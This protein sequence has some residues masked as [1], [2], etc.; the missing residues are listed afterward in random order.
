[1][2]IGPIAVAPHR[3]INGIASTRAKAA[4]A[5]VGCE[6]TALTVRALPVFSTAT[7]ALAAAEV[8]EL[9][10]GAEPIAV[11]TRRARARRFRI[12]WVGQAKLA[13]VDLLIKGFKT[14]KKNVNKKNKKTVD[15]TKHIDT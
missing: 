5:V 13:A 3:Q 15:M 2:K 8:A 10:F 1:L 7:A 6:F 12:D 14:K 4:A 11:A 9:T